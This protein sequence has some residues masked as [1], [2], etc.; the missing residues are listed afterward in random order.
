M[1]RTRTYAA[2]LCAAVI[3][4]LSITSISAQSLVGVTGAVTDVSGAALGQA[5]VEALVAGR[6]VASVVTA[7][8]GRYR[9]EIPA[10]VPFELR[11]RRDGFA[12][13]SLRLTGAARDVTRDV[14]MQIRGVSDTL[15]VTTSR[16]AEERAAVTESVTVAT[17]ADIEALGVPAL[18]DV[19]KFV[20]GLS[21]SAS[22]REGA[23]TSVFARG[24]ESDYNLV[25]IDGVRV[26]ANG[27]G[28]DFSRISASEIE[29]VEV[30]RGA[31]SALWGSDAMGS[32]VQ[33]FTGRAVSG[34]PQAFGTIEGGSFNTWRGD[35]HVAG[36]TQ[37]HVDYQAGVTYR[38][39]DGAFDD[40]LP[41]EDWFEQSTFDG[42]LGAKIG[43]RA[44]LQTSL[45]ASRAQGRSV[46]NVTFGSRDSGG[47]YDTEDVSWHTEV[48]HTVG[49]RFTG[50][51]SFNY[52]QANSVSQDTVND[53]PFA[54]YAIL[55][56]TPGAIYPNGTR[57][58][59]LI[60]VDEFDALSAAGASPAPGQ[61]LASAF[62]F[63]FPFDART[64]FRRPA[65]RYQGDLLWGNGQRFSAGY[66]WERETNP[67]VDDFELNNNAVFVQQQSTIAGRW[68]VAAGLRVDSR[69]SYDTFVSPKV[70]AGGFV[71]PARDGGFSS[72]KVFGSIGRG[73]KAPG[74][75]ERFGDGFADPSPDLKVERARTA[76]L[77]AELTF[78]DQRLR[79]S[80]TYFNNAYR[81]Q[82]AYRF[83]PTGDGIPEY[84]NIDGSDAD[85]WELEAAVQRPVYGIT[86]S[87]SYSYV[88]TRVVTALSTSQQF[89]PGQPLLRRPRHSGALRGGYSAGRVTVHGDVLFIGDRHDNSFLFFESV[90]NA[91]MPQPVFTDITVNP[92]YVVAG[93]GVDVHL[94]RAMTAFIRAS[95]IGDTEYDAV[96]GYPGMP[97]TVMA[98]MRFA[99]GK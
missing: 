83:G 33:I 79:T 50:A 16:G 94:D 52:F 37:R 64:E 47:A 99:L 17:R 29:R 76:D 2:L 97:R 72:L 77:G 45:R 8:A 98:G 54:T 5:T 78:V 91:S 12:D 46:G 39:S 40:I 36:G 88:D 32:V 38:R 14:T 82:V 69:E 3:Q 55:A 60:D 87:G 53:A 21:V 81:D 1:A 27:G 51:G 15:V 89:Q 59:R 74:F 31:Q 68:F 20:P 44:S 25:L 35:V 43:T 84:V 86:V 62:S 42:R 70:S 26:N 4:V 49:T 11:V 66:E 93:L 67:L 95:N 23:L 65:V 85:G 13:V 30:V 63:D 71:V 7:E 41:E 90:P 48:S 58:V 73:V 22:G 6:P 96:I 24:G 19:L 34:S 61:F 10:G 18:S 56:G 28:F 80:V 57:L 9:L 92:G 75:A